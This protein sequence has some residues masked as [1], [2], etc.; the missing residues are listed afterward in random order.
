M[1]PK[2]KPC[3]FCGFEVR[4][5]FHATTG[6]YSF[7]CSTLACAARPLRMT[8]K[9]ARKAIAAWNTRKESTNG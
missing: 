5:P 9:S 2:L 4:G 3:P 7:F 6:V 8:A 1:K